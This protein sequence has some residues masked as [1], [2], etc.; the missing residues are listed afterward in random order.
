MNLSII[1]QKMEGGTITAIAVKQEGKEEIFVIPPAPFESFGA[2]K[3]VIEKYYELEEIWQESKREYDGAKQR[4]DLIDFR[5][6]AAL[7]DFKLLI[8][9]NETPKPTPALKLPKPE[10]EKPVPI[11][12][13]KL[14]EEYPTGY[15]TTETKLEIKDSRKIVPPQTPIEV[16]RQE[17]QAT[18]ERAEQAGV[19]LQNAT[20]I[21]DQP[22]TVSVF[23]EEA[24][25]QVRKMLKERPSLLTSEVKDVLP[26]KALRVLEGIESRVETAK[27]MA[28]TSKPLIPLAPKKPISVQ[29]WVNEVDTKINQSLENT[30]FDEDRL[31]SELR[32]CGV[33]DELVIKVKNQLI[34]TWEKDE[35]F[36]KK[37]NKLFLMLSSLKSLP[38]KVGIGVGRKKKQKD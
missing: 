21:V 20:V 13:L 37:E 24:E 11:S 7:R 32:S 6:K 5:H 12:T 31:E 30:E 16:A 25:S 27:G 35:R 4:F 18:Q 19:E 9:P 33:P 3:S 10:I 17:S 38:Q 36:E 28:D 22:E 8:S 34:K 15:E 26:E 14:P 23:P 1:P 2:M 29:D